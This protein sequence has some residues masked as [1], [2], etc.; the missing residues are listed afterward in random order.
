MFRFGELSDL[1]RRKRWIKQP[2]ISL[3]HLGGF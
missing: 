3:E 1:E 2:K